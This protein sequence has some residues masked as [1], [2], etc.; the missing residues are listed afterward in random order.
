MSMTLFS[1]LTSG[2]FLSLSFTSAAVLFELLEIDWPREE[3]KVT[4]ISIGRL[5]LRIERAESIVANPE[6]F[7]PVSQYWAGFNG[8]KIEAEDA[9]EYLQRLDLLCAFAL[10]DGEL[11][12]DY[13]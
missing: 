9:M 2:N 11:F 4:S 7:E 3:E 13:Q 1:N 10:A 5:R 6:K 8:R 12:M